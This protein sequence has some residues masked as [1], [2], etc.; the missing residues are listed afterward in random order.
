[1]RSERSA[2]FRRADH[3]YGASGHLCRMSIVVRLQACGR[4]GFSFFGQ[5]P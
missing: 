2:D 3:R 5:Q 4:E 1:M